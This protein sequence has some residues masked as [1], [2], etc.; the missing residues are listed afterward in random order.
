MQGE[1]EEKGSKGMSTASRQ[2]VPRVR[3][4]APLQTRLHRSRYGSPRSPKC[5]VGVRMLTSHPSVQ[6]ID[7]RLE[8]ESCGGCVNG[9]FG[10]SVDTVGGTE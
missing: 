9:V 3:Q 6:C 10:A 4:L 2:S 7:L 1:S 5:V 8:L